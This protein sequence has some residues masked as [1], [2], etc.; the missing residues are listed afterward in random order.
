MT[1]LTLS[2]QCSLSCSQGLQISLDPS[3]QALITSQLVAPN[4]GN[5]CPGPLSISLFNS[6]GQPLP[7]PLTC[8][9]I[10]L[11]ITARVRHTASGNF[12]D[13]TL[14]V[15]DGL[16]P[17][18]SDCGDVMVFCNEETDPFYI[19]Y[20]TGTDNCTASGDLNFSHFD[21]ETNLGCGQFQNGLPVLKRI[22][23]Q[24]TVS[25]DAGNSS[26]CLQR[27]WIKHIRPVDLVFPPNRDNIAAPALVCG[28]DPDDL[29]ITGQPTV[30][31][32]PVGASPAC[33]MAVTFTN[34]TIAH[35][36]PGGV[37]VLRNWTAIDFCTGT[38]TNRTQ[39]IRVEDTEA[40]I[41][42]APA[43]LTIGT[44][45]FYCTGSLTLPDAQFSDNCSAVT[46]TP[47]WA[48]GTGYGPFVGIA[49]GDHSVLYTATDACG[50]QSTA[51]MMVTVVDAGPPQAN[52]TAD[53]Q[54]SLSSNGG[55]LVHASTINAGSF[56]NCSPVFLSISRDEV[57]YLPAITVDCADMAAPIM[58]TLRVKDAAG[59][60]NFC[61]TEVT[62]RD[63][64]KPDL[65]CPSNRTLT[66]L[67][68]YTDI[69]LTG[70]ATATD[71]CS[72]E[73]VDYQDIENLS[74]CNNGTVN[75]IWVA[76]DAEGNGKTC[77]QVI[78]LELV[79]GTQVVFP[80]NKT[81]STCSTPS[82]LLP[83]ATGAP[84]ISGQA[85]SAPSINYTDQV[86]SGP[87]P[88]CFRIFR[89]WKVIDHCIYDL[90]G[91]TAG[92]WESVQVIEVVDNTAPELFIP[93]DITVAAD[94]LT[95]TGTVVLS[96]A[97]ALDCSSPIT[98]SHNSLYS[99]AGNTLNA[100][101]IYPVG[102]HAVIFTA[103][104]GCGNS[105]QKTLQITVLD[106]TPPTAICLPGQTVTLDSGGVVILDAGQFDG[107]CVDFCT[108][109]NA[110][111]FQ[112]F[113]QSFDCQ[114]IGLQSIVLQVS[115]LSGNMATCSTFVQVLDLN[116]TC[117]GGLNVSIAGSIRTE[118]G[119][120][121]HNIP[122]QVS[123]PGFLAETAA[124]TSGYFEFQ[125]IPAGADY[126][127]KPYNNANWLNGVT[128]YDL[129]LISKHI[130]GLEPLNSPYK[131]LAAD[132]NL[133]GSITTFDIVQ[134]RKLILGIQDSVPGNTSWR[135][136]D[137]TFIFPNPINPFA[138]AIPEKIDFN[139]LNINQFGQNFVG[140]KV[141]DLNAT[142]NVAQARTLGDTAWLNME[143]RWL[144]A[145]ETYVIPLK[146][147][148]WAEFEGL[149][150]ELQANPTLLQINRI[151]CPNP[152]VLGQEHVAYQSAG[153][154]A[155]SWNRGSAEA[156]G[157]TILMLHITALQNTTLS[158]ALNIDNQRIASEWYAPN[159]EQSSALML[160][161]DQPLSTSTPT[162][163]EIFPNPAQSTF[164]IKNPIPTAAGVLQCMDARGQIMWT[165]SGY[166]PELVSIREMNSLPAGL[167]AMQW[168]SEGAV[169]QG[170][171]VWQ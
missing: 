92:V 81:V 8:A 143:N 21:S 169:F 164:W 104:D 159:T 46:V 89:T 5:S 26:T 85:C 128:T 56:D 102:Q 10:G 73:S 42:T 35:C 142:A 161:F 11:P 47:T 155:L 125:D 36:A 131:M 52:C 135:F 54:V 165:K 71:N 86:F 15:M 25:D 139:A 120:P 112:V 145:G 105:A 129:V 30:N 90:N 16:S 18:L 19:G 13:A 64:L 158:S 29:D 58:L 146:L 9:Q 162:Q 74:A 38:I 98:F 126:T 28:E 156:L 22:D 23:R 32:V 37:T 61:Q 148:R 45:G 93:A 24:W 20:P 68:D 152:T 133:S 82:Q 138:T 166:L 17:V 4:A 170:K 67:Q 100:S 99:T 31:G 109:Q 110:L 55:A 121:V 108:A 2:A 107:G 106:Q 62:V 6:V 84:I 66:C 48:Y 44:D 69:G 72:L 96:D 53:L 101:G 116:H 122:I 65:Q 78:T 140:I 119:L 154:I 41:L 149:Q 60:E 153:K 12:C 63:F 130:L 39:I 114:Q 117:I 57:E 144:N 49:E 151:E 70:M 136:V 132:A 3:G 75:R 34:Q 95:C 163:L 94:A 123:T 103:T 43:D 171:L 91:G 137:S 51:T 147:A 113:P 27:I 160:T 111:L 79:N 1:C 157:E 83:A 88:A 134:L 97:T 80:A 77:T 124:D 167:Y 115:D 141:G 76:T 118:A 127:L 7:N 50:N 40:P 59:L 14:E 168:R 87:P 33:E 150:F